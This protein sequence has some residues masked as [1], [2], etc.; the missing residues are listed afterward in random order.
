MKIDQLF[1]F[2]SVVNNG[3]IN[4]AAY[5]LFISQSSLS[6]SIR[7]LEEEVG[8]TLLVRTTQGIALTSLG[9]EFYE[10]ASNICS[11]YGQLEQLQISKKY[12]INHRMRISSH[13]LSFVE[14]AFT[15]TF[16]KYQNQSPRFSLVQQPV[17]QSSYDVKNGLSDV[18]IYMCSSAAIDNT[19]RLLNSLN[20]KSTIIAKLP[21]VILVS[22]QHPLATSGKKA[23]SIKALNPYTFVTGEG[24]IPWSELLS[25]LRATGT[26]QAQNYVNMSD[27]TGLINFIANTKTYSLIPDV[28]Q[29]K[30]D[31]HRL[32]DAPVITIPLLEEEYYF[33]VGWFKRANQELSACCFDFV[34][35]LQNLFI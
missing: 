35:Y 1:Q 6:R 18:G 28:E 2:V 25:I 22:D 16:K 4:K 19:H 10:Y 17:S 34:C 7:L 13:P 3:S 24:N 29:C 20:L 32:N 23:V 21:M 15:E 12:H 27:K 8:D 26:E 11:N 14:Y 30:A 33:E 31:L 5:E 9:S